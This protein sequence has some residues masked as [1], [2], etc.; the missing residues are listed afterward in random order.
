VNDI[1]RNEWP[2]E[3]RMSWMSLLNGSTETEKVIAWCEEQAT[4]DLNFSFKWTNGKFVED[5]QLNNFVAEDD[6]HTV[7]IIFKTYLVGTFF[8]F[9]REQDY[10]LFKLAWQ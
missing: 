10:M 5:A 3:Y 8:Y 4:L 6:D 1:D 2:F 7:T 9:K